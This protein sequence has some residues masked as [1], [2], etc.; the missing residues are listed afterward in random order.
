MTVTDAFRSLRASSLVSSV[1]LDDLLERWRSALVSCLP[2]E[3]RRLLERR[4][5]SLIVAPQ[6]A[7][8]SVV[9]S[10]G[11]ES[12]FLG[13]LD[14][15]APGSL[16]A[17]LAGAKGTKRKI[18]VQLAAD[19]VLKREV[20]FP[21]QVRDNLTQVLTYEMDRLSPFQPD[22]VYFDFR[23][24]ADA[25]PRDKVRL[26]L[27]LCPRA[28]VQDW[29]RCLRDLG[30]LVDQLTWEGTWPKANLLPLEERPRRGSGP[31]SM[32]KLIEV[33]VSLLAAAALLTP[34][35]QMQWMRDAREAQ[36]SELKA[37]AEEVNR[38]RTALEQARR[39][40]TE[41]L[42]RK[43]EQPR[44]IDLLLELTERLPDNTWV[45][46]MDYR[47]GVVE[48]RGESAQAT[49]LINL[50]DQG[51]GISDVSF[52]SPVVQIRGSGRERF[53][54]SLKYKRPGGS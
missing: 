42:Q 6:G 34:I 50:L 15:K 23:V 40:S 21:S 4:E 36:I 13:E 17:V 52:G 7:T 16:Q 1:L 35:W 54:I 9:L 10:R 47:D 25:S 51:P 28:Q 46:N 29:L 19:Q 31:F 41:V 12:V 26:E 18:L 33:L 2:R 22:Q 3:W 43:L 5:Q 30:A 48:I 44:I 27:A 45:Q 11:D 38:T 53:Q 39:G 24:L 14:P 49:S 8:A 20:A 32:G 37:R